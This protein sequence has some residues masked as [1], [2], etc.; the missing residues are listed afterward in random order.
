MVDYVN[1][2][3]GY[4]QGYGQGAQ[5]EDELQQNTRRARQADWEAKY[6]NP[7]KVAQEQYTTR[8]DLE[9]EPSEMQADPY[10]VSILRAK[11]ING[12]LDA[13]EQL[14]QMTGDY[15]GVNAVGQ[16]Y[17][18]N[19]AVQPGSALEN[20]GD[21]NR[22][23]QLY[24]AQG[25][26]AAEQ[27]QAARNIEEGGYYGNLNA[28][29][30]EAARVRAGGGAASGTS[31]LFPAAPAPMSS[32]SPAG[33]APAAASPAAVTPP[34]PYDDNTD[35]S[36]QGVNSQGSVMKP[37][38]ELDPMHQAHIMHYTSQLTGHPI[39]AV[40]Q[41]IAQQHPAYQQSAQR[42]NINFNT[43]QPQIA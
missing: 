43:D 27:A 26:S 38:H 23:L 14:G 39:E 37:F 5:L 20:R 3:G 6:L 12:D 41:H 16:K 11:A 4:A 1:P 29:R 2:F 31:R 10:A 24:G 28:A 13:A 15:Q 8:R 33:A 9:R 22:A 30:I 21:F 42:G 18:R 40:A 36:D 32:A 35:Y 34:L 19:Y 17:D 25:R 7:E